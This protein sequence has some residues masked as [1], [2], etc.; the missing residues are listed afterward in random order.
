[1]TRGVQSA[2][3][4]KIISLILSSSTSMYRVPFSVPLIMK[5][6]KKLIM[7]LL[8]VMF[9]L[10]HYLTPYTHYILLKKNC[11]FLFF[12]WWISVF[13]LSIVFLFEL[14]QIKPLVLLR[15]MLTNL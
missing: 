12:T 2:S 13:P 6:P 8:K 5:K 3:L 7:V 11:L 4:S 15:D 9:F 14:K 1:M 10:S